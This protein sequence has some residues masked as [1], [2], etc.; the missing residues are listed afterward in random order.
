MDANHFDEDL[1]QVRRILEIAAVKMAAER[2]TDE[3]LKAIK[4]AQQTFVDRTLNYESGVEENILFHLQVVNASNNKVLKS[5]FMKIM[6]DL[7]M[8]FNKSKQQDDVKYLRGI[9]EHDQIIDY[10]IRQNSQGAE[11]AMEVHLENEC[12]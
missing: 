7:L 8:M 11:Q 5:L 6:P 12:S 1:V 2:R 3:D 10:I 4:A 9:K